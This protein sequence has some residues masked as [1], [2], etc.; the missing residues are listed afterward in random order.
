MNDPTGLLT[1][2]QTPGTVVYG[3]LSWRSDS[4]MLARLR[5]VFI[6]LMADAMGAICDVAELEPCYTDVHKPR[7]DWCHACRLT[8]LAA[9][10]AAVARV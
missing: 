4:Q 1:E 10:V 3:L 2:A 8:D 7:E 5:P 9:R 6:D